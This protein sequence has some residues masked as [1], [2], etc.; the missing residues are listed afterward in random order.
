MKGSLELKVVSGNM[1][2][3]IRPGDEGFEDVI[4]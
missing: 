4:V 2:M 1:V 3:M